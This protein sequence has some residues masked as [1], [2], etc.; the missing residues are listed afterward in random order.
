MV[1]GGFMLLTT[2]CRGR[3]SNLDLHLLEEPFLAT[4]LKRPRQ[5]WLSCCEPSFGS[6]LGL[7]TTNNCS[8]PVHRWHQISKLYFRLFFKWSIK[9]EATKSE[10]T[11][12]TWKR[13][14]FYFCGKF[15]KTILFQES[16]ENT[17]RIR[18]E[19]F[20]EN[21]KVIIWQQKEKIFA[22]VIIQNFFLLWSF[23][24]LCGPVKLVWGFSCHKFNCRARYIQMVRLPQ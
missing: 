23:K 1:L 19:N 18:I 24:G 5:L 21:L 6:S 20:R 7:I 11:A 17:S 3:D 8:S 9:R 4:E 16:A 13:I 22:I 15:L 2:L 12:K 10:K 14:I